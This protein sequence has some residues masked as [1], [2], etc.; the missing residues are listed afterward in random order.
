MSDRSPNGLRIVGDLLEACWD[1]YIGLQAEG[2]RIVG[3]EAID[4][5][6]ITTE[7]EEDIS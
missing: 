5:L 6:I 7:Y 1:R 4:R 2:V 3:P